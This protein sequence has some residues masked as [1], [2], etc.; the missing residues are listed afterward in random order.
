[1]LTPAPSPVGI[2]LQ[3]A[4]HMLQARMEVQCAH[5]TATGDLTKALFDT[6]DI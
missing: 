1:M 2:D 4:V 3:M 6:S 5:V